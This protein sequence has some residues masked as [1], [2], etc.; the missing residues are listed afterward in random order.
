MVTPPKPKLPSHNW[1]AATIFTAAFVLMGGISGGILLLVGL[2]AHEAAHVFLAWIHGVQVYSAGVCFKGPFILRDRARTN[3]A[4]VS[5]ALAGPAAS[6]V[7]GV[8]LFAFP[9]TG[10]HWAGAC[11]LLIGVTNLL[12]LPGSDGLRAGRALWAEVRERRLQETLPARATV[13]RLTADL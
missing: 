11:N 12:P 6:L 13:L 5:I 7:F 9:Q 1:A 10:F 4:E 8:V 3:L 2:A